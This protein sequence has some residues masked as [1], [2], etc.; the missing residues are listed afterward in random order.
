MKRDAYFE[1]YIKLQNGNRAYPKGG[2]YWDITKDTDEY[3]SSG[4]LISA[5]VTSEDIR[6]FNA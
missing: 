5:W 1:R 4:Y 3:M 6:N 2:G